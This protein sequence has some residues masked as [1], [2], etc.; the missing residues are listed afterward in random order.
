MSEER[1][2]ILG[3]AELRQTLRERRPGKGWRYSNKEAERMIAEQY[4]LRTRPAPATEKALR[5]AFE[6]GYSQGHN[7]TVESCVRDQKEAA[8]EYVEAELPAA[9]FATPESKK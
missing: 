9:S 7:D 4:D 1:G 3:P 5:E 2:M 6:S 8:T